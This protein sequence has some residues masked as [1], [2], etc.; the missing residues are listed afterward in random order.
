METRESYQDLEEG[1]LMRE[2]RINKEI[3]SKEGLLKKEVAEMQKSLH[4]V[5]MIVVKLGYQIYDLNY[6]IEILGGDPKQ[7]EL[8]F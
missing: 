4:S 8:K 1:R 5:Q 3:L 7:L 6:K 2:Y